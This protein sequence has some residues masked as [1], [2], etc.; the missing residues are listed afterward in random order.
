MKFLEISQISPLVPVLPQKKELG[1][2]FRPPSS[3]VSDPPSFDKIF[4]CEIAVFYG[5]T[6]WTKWGGVKR[7]GIPK[8]KVYFKCKCNFKF[9]HDSTR[10]SKIIGKDGEIANK[11]GYP[12]NMAW[13]IGLN[14]TPNLK[15]GESYVV[16]IS[17]QSEDEFLSLHHHRG[18]VFN[19]ID[20]YHYQFE[21]LCAPS[22][23]PVP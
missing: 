9:P 21:E 14:D 22:Q 7:G 10:K 3:F 11:R 16:N 2:Y 13:N 12:R 23:M 19:I 8:E 18:I 4:Q 20:Q 1:L 17:S 6:M 15:E 5:K